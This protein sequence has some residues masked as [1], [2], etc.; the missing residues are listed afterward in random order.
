MTPEELTEARLPVNFYELTPEQ[1]QQAQAEAAISAPVPGSPLPANMEAVFKDNPELRSAFLNAQQGIFEH[2]LLEQWEK[3][4]EKELEDYRRPG[5]LDSHTMILQTFPWLR[6]SDVDRVR[7]YLAEFTLES[8]TTLREAILRNLKRDETKSDV[9]AD[10]ENDFKRNKD[11]YHE[12]IAQWILLQN[13]WNRKW[14][15][16]N[17]SVRPTLHPAVAIAA[18]RFTGEKGFLENLRYLKDS[19]ITEE[20]NKEIEDRIRELLIENNFPV[21]AKDD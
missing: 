8:L 21:I 3:L 14:E 5:D 9:Y 11:I 1:Q 2:T 10:P 18:A 16:S 17:S 15:D 20:D 4:L 7:R 12:L 13:L 6:Y 19:I